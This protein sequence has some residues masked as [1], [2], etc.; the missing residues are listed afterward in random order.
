MPVKT[1]GGLELYY[2][3]A[4]TGGET[5]A[6][7]NGIGMTVDSWQPIGERFLGRGFRCLFHDC[8]GQLRSAKPADGHYSMEQHATDF[9]ELL[10][11]LGFDKVHVVGT[12]Y[13]SEIGMLFACAYPER[14]ETLTV[15]AGVSELDALLR[16]A[17]ESWAVAADGGAASLFRCM[18]PWAYSSE[19][20][21]ANQQLLREREEAMTRLPSDYC[22]AFK[23]LVGAFLKLDITDQLKR[24]VCPT[25]VISAERDLIKG[26]TFGRLIHDN[27]ANSEFVVLPRA[28]HAVVLEQ[29]DLVAERTIEF[30]DRHCQV[31]S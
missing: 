15:I 17:V 6:F 11:A 21:A 24:I 31:A 30:I 22:E 25:L 23:R 12:S 19:Y 26:P 13:G 8:R 2:E 16:A 28:G 14:I 3:I 27:I 1:I 9:V 10:D 7:I 18:L 20:L 4:G 29:P 5:V